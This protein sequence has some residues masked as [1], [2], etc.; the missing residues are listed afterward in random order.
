MKTALC[1]HGHIRTFDYCWPHLKQFFIDI[2]NPDIFISA[3]I[4][5]T[6]EFVPSEWS[7]DPHKDAGFNLSSQSVNNQYIKSIINRLNPID[8]HLD[9]YH[10]HDKKFEKIV[11]EKYHKKP[12][13]YSNHRPK[14]IL[15]LNYIR[16]TCLNMKQKHEENKGFKY[17]YVVSTRWDIDYTKQIPIDTFDPTILT[18]NLRWPGDT[19]TDDIWVGGRSE[20]LDIYAQQ[21]ENLDKVENDPNFY[22]APH[23][24]MQT[25][26]EYN[27]IKWDSRNDLGINIRR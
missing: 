13:P 7:T 4:D 26:L 19:M 11:E 18:L 14:G 2:H 5:N 10:L 27:N 15:S 24:W 23:E 3:W 22:I 8:V 12:H 9:H 17:D 1:I 25:W 20:L 16:Y 21:F 6:G